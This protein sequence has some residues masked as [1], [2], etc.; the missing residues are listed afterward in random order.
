MAARLEIGT[1]YVTLS[2]CRST[3]PT[4][5]GSSTTIPAII[6]SS[7]S[8]PISRSRRKRRKYP[9]YADA[10][11]P[12]EAIRGELAES[13]EWKKDPLRVEVRLRKGIMFPEKPGVMA[14][15]ELTAEDVVFSYN[16]L[17]KSPKA[18][19]GYFSYVDKVEATD[20]YT[21][22][23]NFNSFHAEW[24]YRFGWGY[25]S[26]I[27]PKEMADAGATNWKNGNGT[28]P[29]MLTDFVQ[30]NSNTY[31]RNPIYWDKEKIGGS[32]YKL[33]FVDKVIY[34]TIKDE[35]TFL[36]ALRTA[37]R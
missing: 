9:F 13:W 3:R 11:P 33:P 24:D 28:G 17:A 37:T 29:F 10:Y 26:P 5:T 22:V 19:N 23:F 31:S 14:S 36:T 4:G 18:Q 27:Y 1:V 2:H 6:S 35:A 8:R 16:R 25:Y 20:R 30:G 32:E 12:S 34:R 21:V 7:C 15:R